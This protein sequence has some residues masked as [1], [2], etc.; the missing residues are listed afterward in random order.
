MVINSRAITVD[1]LL[2]KLYNNPKSTSCFTS[3]EPL[4]REARRQDF[5]ISRK[6]VKDYLSRNSTYTLHRRVVRKFKHLPTIASGLHTDWQSDLCDLA[7]VVGENRGFRYLLVCIDVLSRK[8]FISPLRRKTPEHMISAL[9]KCFESAEALPWILYTDEGTEYASSAI[10]KFYKTHDIKHV[11]LV[12]SPRF[13]CGI[14]ER[15]NRTIKERLYRYFTKAGT[16]HWLNIVDKLINSINC[17]YHSG[18]DMAPND[19]TYD[20]CAMVRDRLLKRTAILNDKA[21]RR[22]TRF[23]LGD[24][25]RVEK[26]KHIFVKGYLPTFTNEIF[27]VKHVL[28][29]HHPHTYR[30]INSKGDELREQFYANELCYVEIDVNKTYKIDKI[31]RTIEKDGDTFHLVRWYGKNTLHDSWINGN[32]LLIS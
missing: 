22:L 24:R 12:T 10:N 32:D 15:A 18:I 5:K 3:I 31:V 1:R 4:L 27:T 19:I 30:L 29:H 8:I 25:V 23:R 13:H 11:C 17:S 9:K 20:N 26:Y 7:D 6:E 14:V 2:N 21:R 16:Y 28:Q